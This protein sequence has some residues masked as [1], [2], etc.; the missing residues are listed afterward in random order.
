MVYHNKS[1][2]EIVFC[3]I[4][5]EAGLKGSAIGLVFDVPPSRL[6]SSRGDGGG[7]CLKIKAYSVLMSPFYVNTLKYYPNHIVSKRAFDRVCF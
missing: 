5:Y 7:R 4:F 6:I 2:Y 3:G 1:F